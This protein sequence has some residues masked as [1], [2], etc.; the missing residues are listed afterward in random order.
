MG[1]SQFIVATD[2]IAAATAIAVAAAATPAG[3]YAVL[4]R[5]LA[6]QAM[7]DDEGVDLL[8]FVGRGR[9]RSSQELRPA[10]DTLA[11]C[12]PKERII[13][14][15]LPVPDLAAMGRDNNEQCDKGSSTLACLS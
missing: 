13:A 9:R 4:D 11:I 3:T 8:A 1:N 15:K 7:S 2:T 12:D 5:V 14:L 6:L 10:C